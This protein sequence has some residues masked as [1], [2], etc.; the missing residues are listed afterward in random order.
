[1]K[2]SV[3][4]MK[5]TTVN[6]SFNV[7]LLERIDEVA[8]EEARSRSELVRDATRAYIER[9]DR[10]QRLLASAEQQAAGKGLRQQ[11]VA[12]EIASCRRSSAAK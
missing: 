3:R 10:W 4:G 12:A 6:M 5:S 11:D 2:E 8:Q 7:D 9:K 1:M